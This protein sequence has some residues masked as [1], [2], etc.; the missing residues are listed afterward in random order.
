MKQKGYIHDS[1]DFKQAD[2]YTSTTWEIAD[3]V[4]CNYSNEAD[5][6]QAIL[7]MGIPTFPTHTA[8]PHCA[9][10]RVVRRWEK[11]IDGI[12]E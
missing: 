8:P 1:V 12:I 3:H 6:W 11:R 2:M 5:V 10:T 4:G 9:D 7:K